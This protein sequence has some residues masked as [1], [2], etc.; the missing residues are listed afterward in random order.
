MYSFI[1]LWLLLY[2]YFY[3]FIELFYYSRN[4]PILQYVTKSAFWYIIVDSPVSSSFSVIDKE[5]GSLWRQLVGRCIY[6]SL[7][8]QLKPAARTSTLLTISI[9][10]TP[11]HSF[12]K[13][14][15]KYKIKYKKILPFSDPE[16]NRSIPSIVVYSML[17]IFDFWINTSYLAKT[18]TANYILQI[19]N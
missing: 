18:Q 6:M 14:Y 2:V 1:T 17:R 4:F 5:G 8:P 10:F 7:G 9:W 3:S 12:N 15:K 13:I 16:Q 19:V 11:T